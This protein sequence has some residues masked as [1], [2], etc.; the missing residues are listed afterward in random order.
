MIDALRRNW[1]H[2]LMEGL[3]LGLFMISA[4]CFTTLLEHPASPLRAALPDPTLRRVLTGLAM[5]LTAVGLIYSPW[6]RRSGAHLNPSVTLAFL[7]LG[8]V[9]PWDGTFYVLAQF[10]GGI[11]GMS[12]AASALGPE[13]AHPAVHYIVTEPGRW[14]AVPAFG[15]E[16]AI[17]FV[18]MLTVLNVSS[19]P[20]LAHLTGVVA[21]SL[22]ALWIGIEA[23]VSGMSMNPARSLGSAALAHEGRSLW[24]YFVAPPLGMLAAVEVFRRVRLR[25]LPDGREAERRLVCAKLHHAKGVRCIFCEHRERRERLESEVTP[26]AGAQPTAG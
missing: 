12:V 14:G 4:A 19:A 5:G 24:L 15:A 9:A 25:T 8:R 13:L 7:R 3:G 16:A 11:A 17:S 18:L 21:G 6:G 10:A 23:P 2:Y 22:V 20:R 1:S 26:R